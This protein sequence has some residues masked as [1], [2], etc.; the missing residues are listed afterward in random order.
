VGG[1]HDD[2]AA[3]VEALP[4]VLETMHH[5]PTLDVIRIDTRQAQ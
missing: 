2:A 1:D 3:P 4:K 5:E